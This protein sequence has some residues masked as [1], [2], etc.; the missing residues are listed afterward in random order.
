M[1]TGSQADVTK[2]SPHLAPFDVTMLA[3]SGGDVTLSLEQ[4]TSAPPRYGGQVPVFLKTTRLL[5]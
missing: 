5:L 3:A 2:D 1:G 4:H